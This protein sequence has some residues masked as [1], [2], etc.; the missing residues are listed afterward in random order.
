MILPAVETVEEAVICL[1]GIL[2]IYG[3]ICILAGVSCQSNPLLRMQG[4]H[5]AIGEEAAKGEQ[6]DLIG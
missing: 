1:K 6:S 2:S 3:E 4:H 5:A